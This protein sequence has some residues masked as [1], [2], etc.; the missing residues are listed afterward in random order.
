M[1]GMWR[2]GHHDRRDD[3]GHPGQ[4]QRHIQ[5]QSSPQLDFH[6]HFS[7]SA[8]DFSIHERFQRREWSAARVCWAD[9]LQPPG[10]RREDTRN[11]HHNLITSGVSER[12]PVFAGHEAGPVSRTGWGEQLAPAWPGRYALVGRLG[13]WW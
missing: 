8:C 10:W 11:P 2:D 9:R 3:G 7:E 5:K 1:V 4:L 6:G 13:G 12:L